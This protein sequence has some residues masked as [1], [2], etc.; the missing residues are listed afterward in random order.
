LPLATTWKS[1]PAARLSRLR[2]ATVLDYAR[3]A[4]AR[5]APGDTVHPWA[6]ASLHGYTWVS[7]GPPAGPGQL[8]LTAPTRLGPGGRIVLLT[9]D[10][11]RRF[12]VS[13]VIRT[14]AQ[15]AFYARSH[16]PARRVS[17]SRCSRA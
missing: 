6:A 9:A 1:C 10:G 14:G 5:G 15:A 4:S 3:Y 17:P 2:A 13:G 11:P 8:V 12:T 7:G 16:W